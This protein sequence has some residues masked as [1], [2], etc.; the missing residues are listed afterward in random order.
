[1]QDPDVLDTWFSSALWTHSTL[2]WP[3]N[4]EDFRYFYPTSVMETG[5][6]I[7]FFWVARMIMMGLEDTGEIPFHTVYLHGLLRDEKGEKM[8]KFR[9]N[10]L[11][12]SEAIDKYGIDALRFALI[13]G[14]SP[15]SDINLGTGKLQSSRNFGNKLWNATRFIL[16]NLDT[17]VAQGQALPIIEADKPQTIEDRW[18]HSQLNRL[19]N[20]IAKL[21][22]DFQFGEAAQRIYEFLWSQFCDWYI[23]IA[24]IRLRNNQSTPSALPFLVNTLETSL[25]LLHPFMPFITEELWQSLKQ[26]LPDGN[27]MPASIVVAPYPIAS[28][29]AIDPEAERI[30]DSVIEIIRS[31]RNARAQYKVTPS[32]WIEAQVYADDLLPYISSQAKIIETLGHARPLTILTR[33]ERKTGEEALVMVLKETEVVLPWAGMIDT[34]AEKL[35]LT[36]EMELNQARITQLDTRLR[37][38]AFL[39]KAPPHIIEKEKQKLDMLKDRSERLNLELSQL[40]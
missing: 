25:R 17:K 24:K 6:D 23:E 33:E 7:L 2:G 31:I 19:V 18:I 38:S 32:K 3:E 37:D 28:G 20:N 1:M 15:G 16:Q 26:H 13:A 21:M 9:G 40:G 14:N 27:Q 29:E 10:V 39:A 11:N 4:T 5:Y 30:M 36:R 22:Q 35:R 8:S 12:P 34:A